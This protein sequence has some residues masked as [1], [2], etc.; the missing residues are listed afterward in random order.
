M[1]TELTP[2]HPSQHLM[3]AKEE[4]FAGYNEPRDKYEKDDDYIL[5]LRRKLTRAHEHLQKVS[6]VNQG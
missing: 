1:R 2:L 4:V 5:F 3:K 6:T